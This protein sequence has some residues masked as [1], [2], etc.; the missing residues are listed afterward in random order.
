MS[1]LMEYQVK[2]SELWFN[3]SE[4]NLDYVGPMQM[5]FNSFGIQSNLGPL[6]FINLIVIQ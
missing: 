3:N 6:V 1:L 4:S 5:L 2:K